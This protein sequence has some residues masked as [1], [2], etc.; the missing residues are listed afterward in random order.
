MTKA[1]PVKAFSGNFAGI[2]RKGTVSPSEILEVKDNINLELPGAS[3][4]IIGTQSENK[5]N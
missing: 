3:F 2:T 1:G 4:D 5:A